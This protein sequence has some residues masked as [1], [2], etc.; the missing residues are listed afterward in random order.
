M[1]DQKYFADSV[2]HVC[3]IDRI[4]KLESYEYFGP[5]SIPA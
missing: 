5:S 2:P 3:D 4:E 1:D